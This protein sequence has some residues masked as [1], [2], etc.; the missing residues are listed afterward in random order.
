[1]HVFPD[2]RD[3]KFYSGIYYVRWS[4]FLRWIIHAHDFSQE[5]LSLPHLYNYTLFSS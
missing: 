3:Y 1:M 5:I 4:D 2:Y